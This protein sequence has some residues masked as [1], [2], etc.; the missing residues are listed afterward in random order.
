[1]G[2]AGPKERFFM[3]N[4]FI[5]KGK[6]SR[7][8]LFLPSLR[9]V[10]AD[11]W[12]DKLGHDA[13]VAWIK[14][15]T[16]VDRSDENRDHDRV[17]YTLE[18]TWE[19]LGIGKKKF[20]QKIIRPLWEYGLIDVVEYEKSNRKSQKPKNIIV[21][22]SPY[23]KH[24]TEIQPLKKLRD[25]DKDYASTSQ[26]H[27]R[28]GG[29]PKNIND[30]DSNDGFQME[31]VDRT[32]VHGFQTETVDGFQTETVTV[33]KQKPN[34]VFNNLL[35]NTNKSS[36]VS[37]NHHL[38]E[39]GEEPKQPAPKEKYDDDDQYKK[40]RNLFLSAGAPDIKNH[41]IH[42][43][44]FRNIIEKQTS[45]EKLIFAAKEYISQTKEA[46]EIAW[47]LGGGYRNYLAEPKAK[48]RNQKPNIELPVAILEAQ[49]EQAASNENGNGYENLNIEARLAEFRRNMQ[50]KLGNKKPFDL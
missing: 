22:E 26:L 14:L 47:F 6:K 10:V 27:G 24:E 3:S 42:Y 15:H 41:E 20:Y 45:F 25:Y 5:K 2:Q 35:I 21:Y 46:S 1:M 29:R 8:E 34:N 48:P 39:Q 13:F 12:I 19:K 11:D 28:K 49:N 38:A 31:T 23:N 32:N 17:P 18:S 4:S 43:P 50:R 30:A 37:N 33:S 16:W 36:N 40:L 44:R 7:N 9:Y